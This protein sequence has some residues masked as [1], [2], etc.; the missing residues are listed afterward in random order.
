MSQVTISEV[1]WL[2]DL[3]PDLFG[4]LNGVLIV[5]FYLEPFLLLSWISRGKFS[6]NGLTTFG[7][8]SQSRHPATMMFCS[9]LRWAA[10]SCRVLAREVHANYG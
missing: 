2:L 9:A 6:Q 10:L 1:E 8:W 7:K 5:D 4:F 3:Y